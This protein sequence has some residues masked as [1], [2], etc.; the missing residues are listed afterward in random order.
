MMEPLVLREPLWVSQWI[1]LS[2]L[3]C[4]GWGF[5]SISVTAT[6]EN[7]PRLH[8]QQLQRLIT[9]STT[10][11]DCV[12]AGCFPLQGAAG[13][14]GAPGFPGPRGPSGPQGA[15]GAP[16]P[17][18]N[19]VSKSLK[20]NT[21]L[22]TIM[23]VTQHILKSKHNVYFFYLCF[24]DLPYFTTIYYDLVFWFSITCFCCCLCFPQNLFPLRVRLVPLELR[25]KLVPRE[26]L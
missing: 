3:A 8:S 14:A 26:K 19:T 25:V 24:I 22:S 23:N 17:K 9:S 13:V 7:F 4:L 1:H 6:L 12:I 2:L 15:T 10:R 16:G 5:E 21:S 20:T 11:F 18:G